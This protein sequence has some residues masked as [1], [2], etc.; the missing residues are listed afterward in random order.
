MNYDEQ[1]SQLV[2]VSQENNSRR[3]LW[4]GSGLSHFIGS[5]SSAV[6]NAVKPAVSAVKKYGPTVAKY[7][8]ITAFAAAD[9]AA[10]GTGA[11]SDIKEMYKRKSVKTA[12]ELAG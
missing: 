6:R 11:T 7:G 8:A 12:A 2:Q 10:K 5:A 9:A 3:R 4:F 1:N